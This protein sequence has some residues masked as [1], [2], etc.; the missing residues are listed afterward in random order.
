MPWF[1]NDARR[2]LVGERNLGDNE[3]DLQRGTST[4]REAAETAS[5]HLSGDKSIL[6][7]VGPSGFGKTRFAYEMFNQTNLVADQVRRAS[8]IYADLVIVGDELTKLAVETA[9]AGSPTF[10]SLTTVQ[11]TFIR[12]W[13]NAFYGKALDFVWSRSKLRRECSRLSERW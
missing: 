8:V 3:L 1:D 11:T 10:S 5:T 7:I 4:F 6:R 9:D 12:L 13:P 2:F